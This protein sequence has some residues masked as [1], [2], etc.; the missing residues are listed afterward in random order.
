MTFVALGLVLVSAFLHASWNF[1]AKRAR[2]GVEFT[3]LFALLTSLIYAPVAIIWLL[4]SS[5][6][7][8]RMGVVFAFASAVLHVGYFL[9][10]QRGYKVGDLSLVYPLA[11]GSGPLLATVGA[12]VLFGERPSYLA[13]LGTVLIVISVFLLAG[14]FSIFRHVQNRQA[15]FYGLLTGLTIAAYTLLDS[16]TVSKVLLAPIL[17]SWMSESFRTLLLSPVAIKNWSKLRLEWQMHRLEALG[18]AILSPLAYLMV[19][20][21]LVFTPVSYIAPAREIS[22]LIGAVLG[23]TVLSEGNKR[24]RLLAASGMVAGVMLLA[25]G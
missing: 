12:I 5:S 22:I 6:S 23:T 14:G 20:T 13:L 11:R 15:V 1:L 3:F 19:L 2:G 10:L 7:I 24:R 9:F 17:L 18:I 25:I 4:F 21:A 8:P 16:F